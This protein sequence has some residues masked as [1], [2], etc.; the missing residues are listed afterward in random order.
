ML[1]RDIKPQN[2]F[3][4]RLGVDYDVLKLLDFG[5]A[6]SFREDEGHLTREGLITGT[7]AYMPPER[8]M[9][10]AADERS[11]LYSLGCVAF[12][13]L[14]GE[15]L[16]TGEPMA[17]MLKHIRTAPRAPS[18]VAKQPVPEDL[19]QIVLACLQKEPE[20]RPASAG[21]LWRMLGD[22]SVAGRWT[23]ESAERWWR[24]HVPTVCG[25]L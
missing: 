4:C 10:Q 15:P 19:D 23:P 22:C 24:E 14:T 16:F 18:A 17:V 6:C 8:G 2:L 13:M 5:L 25:E 3:L 21:E 20:Q 12:Y 7:P 1:H 11:D 9:G